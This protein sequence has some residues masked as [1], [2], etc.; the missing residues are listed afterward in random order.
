[1][2]SESRCTRRGSGGAGRVVHNGPTLLELMARSAKGLVASPRA[3]EFVQYAFRCCVRGGCVGSRLFVLEYGAIEIHRDPLDDDSIP[4]RTAEVVMDALLGGIAA[5]RRRA[6]D[7]QR[8]RVSDP[9]SARAGE[10][11]RSPP[12]YRIRS[13]WCLKKRESTPMRRHAAPRVRWPKR[14]STHGAPVSMGNGAA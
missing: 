11:G 10:L 12:R 9:N 6:V 3:T 5:A 8:G 1:M 14:S 7:R 2:R 4:R 13:R